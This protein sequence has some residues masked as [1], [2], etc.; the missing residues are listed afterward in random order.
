MAQPI[1]TPVNS[2]YLSS[3]IPQMN[4]TVHLNQTAPYPKVKNEPSESAKSAP[5]A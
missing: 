3:T 5:S 4:E 1:I 2:L